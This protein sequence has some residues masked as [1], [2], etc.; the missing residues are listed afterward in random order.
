MIPVKIRLAFAL[1]I[2]ATIGTFGHVSNNHA[3]SAES[4]GGGA[5]FVSLCWPFYWSWE[6]QRP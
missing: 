4:R 5:F 6:L 2:A 3:L 1:Y